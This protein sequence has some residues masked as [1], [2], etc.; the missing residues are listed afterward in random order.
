ML[1]PGHAA[2]LQGRSGFDSEGRKLHELPPF[3]TLSCRDP[4]QR[5]GPAGEGME[6]NQVA[7]GAVLECRVP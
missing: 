1:E 7:E 4:L 3:F 6:Y 2:S 5:G